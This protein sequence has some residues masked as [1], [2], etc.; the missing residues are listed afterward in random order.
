MNVYIYRYIYEC[1][2]IYMNIYIYIY[3]YIYNAQTPS[4]P[5]P[6]LS[7]LSRPTRDPSVGAF[8]ARPPTPRLRG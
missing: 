5:K 8:T 3:I 1:I 6:R 2:Y 4:E 7:V